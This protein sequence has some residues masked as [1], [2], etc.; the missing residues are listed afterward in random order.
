MKHFLRIALAAKISL[1]TLIL[2]VSGVITVSGQEVVT[3]ADDSFLKVDVSEYSFFSKTLIVSEF[4]KIQDAKVVISDETN[5]IYLYPYNQE[6]GVLKQKTE[7]IIGNALSKERSLSESDKQNMIADLKTTYGDRLTDYSKYGVL[8]TE[9]DSCHTSMPFCTGTIYTFPAGTNTSAQV[10]P[11]YN[12]LNTRPNPAWYHLKILDPGPI[13]IYMY[14]TPARDIDFCLWGPFMDPITPCPMTNTNG[15]LTGSKVIDCSYSPNPTETANIP[16]GQTGEYYILIITNFSNQPCNIT[17]QQ[18]SGTGTT[19]CTILPPAASSNSPVCVGESIELEA[20]NAGGATYQWTGPGG[21]FSNQQNPVI[22]NA[23]YSNAGI[24]SVTITVN[25]IQSD[26]SITEVYVYD[27]PT[28]TLTANGPTTICEGDSTQLLISATSVGPFRVTLS[29]GNGLPTVI[30]FFQP[31]K[32][33]WV[34]PNDTTT[35]SLTSVSNNACSGTVSGEV[36]VNVKPKPDPMFSVQNPCASLVTQFNDETT[37][38]GGSASS[39]DWNFGDGS[40]HSNLQDPTHT[41]SAGGNYDITLS[42][43]ANNGCSESITSQQ[44]INPTPSVSAGGDQSIPYGTNTQLSGT[45]S[46]G[47]GVHTY[48]WT[49][50]DKVDNATILNPNTVLLASS[51]D[52]QL[53][54]TDQNGCQKSDEMSIT[55]TGGPL[56]AV[57]QPTPPAICIGEST[58]LNAVS[59]GGSGIYTYTWTSN[60]P[61]FSS[62]IEDPTVTPTETTT[63]LLSIYDNFNTINAQATV[64]VYPKPVIDAG[65]D[66]TIAHGTNTTLT[67]TAT[68]GTSP[69][70][71]QWDPASMVN[72]P[73]SVS[74]TT[75]NI[76]GSTNFN[77]YV[78]DSHLCDQTDQV[79]V[80]VEGGPLQ[81]N[82]IAMQP[83]ICK[84]ESTQLKALPSGGSNQYTSY[85]WTSEPAGFTSL[86][87]EPTVSP[88]VTTLY[89][90]VVDDGYNTTTGSV[91]VTVNPLPEVNLVPDDPR[92]LK[93]SNTEIGI[94]VFDS[95]PVSANNPGASYLWSNGSQ[96]QAITLATSGIT[97]DE[98]TYT[99]TV[100]DPLTEC[101]NTGTITAYF[102]FEYCSYGIKETVSDNRLKVY[103][104]PSGSGIFNMLI[105]KLSGNT[106]IEVY[107]S[108]GMKIFDGNYKLS[109]NDTF[110]E[111]INLSNAPKGVYFLKLKNLETIIVKKLIIR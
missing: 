63:Y 23:Q 104:N 65:A 102:T 13:A 7:E 46:G 2:G 35:Y 43:V 39:W 77:L 100:T 110:K 64:T 54:A 99:V 95:V 106:E 37:V 107:S 8:E 33:I 62:N 91:T 70:Q 29:T 55:V 16:N 67:A 19:D 11:N 108:T 1:I 92:I 12:C 98:Q 71:Y 66:Q 17:F 80:L 48:L 81:V 36:T 14:S 24:Y 83:V 59:S 96:E 4:D 28:A 84:L 26:P 6:L 49:P 87:A 74:T 9:N 38:T 56:S 75:K 45:A 89:T 73:N 57:I 3:R 93:I 101:S 86:L 32:T 105:D 5:T 10:G 22:N 18:N 31:T 109:N 58:T 60:P 94:C 52:F 76:Y 34:Y 69:Y 47:S 53:T 72:S 42:V 68:G 40:S 15:G 50:S 97:F 44:L 111:E 78:Q 88:L 61:G 51:Q 103:P 21:F 82:P 30:N 79:S 90:V 25:G 27:P 85:S 20:A 41:Y